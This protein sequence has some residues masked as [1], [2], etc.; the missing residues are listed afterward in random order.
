MSFYRI[1]D[2]ENATAELDVEDEAMAERILTIY[3][4][5]GADRQSYAERNEM[6]ILYRDSDVI[7][8][9]DLNEQAHAWEGTITL[10]QVSEMFHVLR[11][12]TD[13]ENIV[14]TD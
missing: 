6:A 10:V 8:A 4:L 9:A 7:Y 12:G 14:G 2:G 3:S 13:R 11:S 5:R 1:L